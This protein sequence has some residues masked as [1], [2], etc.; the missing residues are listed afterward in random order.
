MMNAVG[1]EGVGRLTCLPLWTGWG[2]KAGYLSLALPLISEV[3]RG[4]YKA[5]GGGVRGGG[6][7]EP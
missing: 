4:C 5:C 6:G 2:E 7:E 1:R 3:G